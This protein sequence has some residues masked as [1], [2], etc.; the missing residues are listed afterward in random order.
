MRGIWVVMMALLA[1]AST[2]SPSASAGAIRISQVYP[3]GGPGYG[4]IPRSYRTD[5]VELF[6]ASGLPVDVG[7]WLL[8]YGGPTTTPQFG[9]AGCTA[10]IPSSTVL[11]PCSYL[12]IKVGDTDPIGAE[13]DVPSPDVVVSVPNLSYLTGSLA[14][15]SAGVPTGVCPGF[16]REDLVGWTSACGESGD[17]TS[18]DS[19]TQALLRLGDGLTDTDHN[20]ADFIVVSNPSP[21]NSGSPQNQTCLQTPSLLSTWG[22]IKALHR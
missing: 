15:F 17:A 6:N 7:G 9:C 21:R 20:R 4:L 1:V 13:P 14:V 5:Y 2:S 3:G 10:V 8:A 12:L 19:L 11:G 16:A 18:P 22:R